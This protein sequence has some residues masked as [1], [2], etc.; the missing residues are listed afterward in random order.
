M[1]L[2]F[3]GNF[4]VKPLGPSSGIP[5]RYSAFIIE[6]WI[7]YKLTADPGVE[8]IKGAFSFWNDRKI[9]VEKGKALEA[10]STRYS[11]RYL[12]ILQQTAPTASSV[13]TTV[14]FND[15]FRHV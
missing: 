10:K 12:G 14:Q 15:S 8:D 1:R 3:T 7:A 13:E 5:G 11:T 4:T 9:V 2:V 6:A